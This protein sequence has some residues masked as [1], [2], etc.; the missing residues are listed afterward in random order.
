MSNKLSEYTVYL[1]ECRDGTWY[2]G[3]TTDIERRME[4]HNTG[5]GCKYTRGRRPVVLCGLS[6]EMSHSEALKLEYR[7]KKGPKNKKLDTLTEGRK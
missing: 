3:I 5:V 6:E 1:I 7:V 4:E 2:C